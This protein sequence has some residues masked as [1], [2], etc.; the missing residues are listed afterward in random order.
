MG[1]QAIQN[2]TQQPIDKNGSVLHF[3]RPGTTEKVATTASTTAATED[4]I[5]RVVCDGAA[6]IVLNSTAT[7]SHILMPA[8]HVETFSL[9]EG[10]Q[11]NV[12]G[13]NMY[14]TNLE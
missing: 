5:V 3:L 13:A 11:I 8:N 10:D 9:T 6:H 14:V 4:K 1:K 12:L 2:T 7:T